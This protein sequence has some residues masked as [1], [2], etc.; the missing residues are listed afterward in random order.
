M[1][2]SDPCMSILFCKWQKGMAIPVHVLWK[3]S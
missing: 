3:E 1:T 2:G